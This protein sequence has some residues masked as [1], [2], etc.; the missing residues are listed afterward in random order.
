MG[1]RR[2]QPSPRPRTVRV[3]VLLAA[4]IVAVAG[5]SRGDEV[6]LVAAE[7]EAPAGTVEEPTP[8]PPTPPDLIAADATEPQPIAVGAPTLVGADGAVVDLDEVV[9]TVPPGAVPAGAEIAVWAAELRGGPPLE[10]EQLGLP[11]IVELDS[12]TLRQPIEVRWDLDAVE[13][14]L[15]RTAM[16]V[17]WDRDLGAWAA[18][19]EGDATVE[20]RDSQLVLETTS[21]S[22]RSWIAR[23][24][25]TVGEIVGARV[26]APTCDDGPLPVWV[27]DVVRPDED[28][29][30]APLRTCTAPDT[31][32]VITLRVA[33]NRTFSQ[34]LLH[35]EGGQAFAWRWPGPDRPGDLRAALYQLAHERLVTEDDEMLVPPRGTVAVG[36]GRPRSDANVFVRLEGEVSGV[37]ML[38]DIL[39]YAVERL[40][41]AGFDDERLLGQAITAL[42]ECGGSQTLGAGVTA[43]EVDVTVARVL[44][45]LAACST[46][47]MRPDSAFGAALEDAVRAGRVPWKVH[48]Q[49]HALHRYLAGL[50]AAE[51]AF[52]TA[53]VGTHLAAELDASVGFRLVGRPGKLGSWQPSCTDPST[54][55]NLLYRNL[56]LQDVFLDTSKELWEFAAWQPSARTA[57]EPLSTCE[58]SHLLGLADLLPDDWADARAARVVAEEI[59]ALVVDAAALA[60]GPPRPGCETFYLSFVR[61]GELDSPSA[62]V[63]VGRDP[64]AGTGQA[65]PSVTEGV[66]VVTPLGTANGPQG[67]ALL[68]QWAAV[69]ADGTP[70]LWVC[71][72]PNAVD[73]VIGAGPG[74]PEPAMPDGEPAPVDGAAVPGITL[75]LPGALWTVQP[76]TDPLGLQALREDTFYTSVQ[77]RVLPGR[78]LVGVQDDVRASYEADWDVPYPDD[79]FVPVDVPGT[80]RAVR[81][82]APSGSG[83]LAI[84]TVTAEVADHLVV[85]V[86][87]ATYIEDLEVVGA[88]E[89]DDVLGSLRIDPAALQRAIGW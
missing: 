21:F 77:I 4:A 24:G 13:E 85:E 30:A 60:D 51:V 18:D 12:V 5:C 29:T 70:L 34:R 56:A 69:A 87:F 25:Q 17:R 84:E 27:R 49:I 26:D 55:S 54:D 52:Y 50:R 11:V 57:V 78:T 58:P 79:E 89:V 47:L 32:D 35:A 62:M 39:I 88:Q 63:L 23:V 46:E 28:L 71:G 65:H 8:A 10:G 68:A 3:V 64:T 82:W 37:S 16:P 48:R 44:D 73:L 72:H 43:G 67:L 75:D 6:D 86:L 80:R 83:D 45:V 74:A 76:R 22:A 15:R 14:P 7:T 9:V 40:S 81:Y 61:E 53:D 33:G 31:D 20:V 59:R 1:M 41:I 19:V 38:T 36:I 66:R 2:V 42:Y